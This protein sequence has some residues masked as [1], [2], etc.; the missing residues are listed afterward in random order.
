MRKLLF[1]AVTLVVLIS[2]GCRRNSTDLP[3]TES[4]GAVPFDIARVGAGDGV[5]GEWIA[6]Y[7]VQ[8]KL[9]HFHI[10]INSTQTRS[11][12]FSFGKG[13]FVSM[14]DSD[15]TVLLGKLKT[16]LEAKTEP[17]DVKRMAVLPFTLAN[18]GDNMTRSPD[19]GFAANPP[20]GWTAM[21]IFL[22]DGDGEDVELFMNLNPNMKKG[23]FSIK[24]S[25]YG[26]AALSKLA[27]V[28]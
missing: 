17:K 7:T 5:T 18:F 28:L 25:D 16:A 27:G 20:G 21:K 23:E 3:Y 26:D 22:E 4:P 6:T 24:D 15:A 12:G 1:W 8:N 10:V 19:G 13:K 2:V 11:N 9:A 14:P